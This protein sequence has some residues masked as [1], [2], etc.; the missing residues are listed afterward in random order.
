MMPDLYPVLTAPLLPDALERLPALL[1][2]P[3]VTA[4]RVPPDVPSAAGQATLER[5]AALARRHDVA[6][7][8]AIGD[9][10]G[11]ISP[12]LREIADGLH[13][14]GAGN[15]AAIRAGI[16]EG[17]QIGCLCT[18]REEAFL[19]GESGADYVAFDA[20]ET[21]LL[22]WWSAI[23]ELPAVAEGVTTA[24][25]AVSAMAAGADFLA[26]PYQGDDALLAALRQ[27]VAL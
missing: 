6:L 23:A 22:S 9:G 1:S 11:G 21:D 26:F 4:L 18:S 3:E 8:A 2:L 15:L 19:A 12:L 24:E 7:I 10:T 14:A 16:G 27:S 17:R 25:R 5:L 20:G 13:L